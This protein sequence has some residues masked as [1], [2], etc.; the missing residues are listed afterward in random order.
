MGKRGPGR[1]P[2]GVL[3]LRGSWRADAR[4]GEPTPE[5]GKPTCPR[6]LSKD[7]KAIWRTLIPQILHMGILAK[8]D[9]HVLARYCQLYAHWKEAE[10]VLIRQGATMTVYDKLGDPID[11]KDRPEVAR[12]LRLSEQLCRLESKFGLTPSDRA[13]LSSIPAE[14]KGKLRKAKD[15]GRFF[16]GAEGA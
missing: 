15:K 1:T 11:Y 13:S 6:W 12:C 5:F 2:T 4:K 10:A 8:I 3:K 9:G 14:S 7:A 16:A